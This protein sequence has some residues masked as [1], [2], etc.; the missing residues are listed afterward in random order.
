MRNYCF[1]Q[2]QLAFLIPCRDRGKKA[3]IWEPDYTVYRV[4]CIMADG[5]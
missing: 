5:F 3:V 2:G 4:S 1:I